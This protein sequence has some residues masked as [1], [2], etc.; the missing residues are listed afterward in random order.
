MVMNPQRRLALAWLF[1]SGITLFA[2]WMGARHPDGPINPD[3][4]VAVGAIAITVIK[5]RVIVSEFMDVRH[6]PVLLRRVIDA[7]LAC[8]TIA[9]LIAYFFTA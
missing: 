7:W 5:V 4:A 3:P 9:M 8:F 6:A 2:W 1:L